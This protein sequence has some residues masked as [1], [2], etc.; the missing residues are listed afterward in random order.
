MNSSYTGSDFR[1]MINVNLDNGAASALDRATKLLA[2][3][4]DGVQKAAESAL[5]RAGISGRA[6]AAREVGK[7]YYLRSSDFK[8]Y[9]KS[10]Q[11]VSRSGG[12]ITVSLNFRGFHVP[13]IRFKTAL[14]SSGLIR[15]RV[16]R[17]SSGDVLR[18]VFK[19]TMPNS[20]HIGLF[21]R[22]KKT[23]DNGEIRTVI[24]QKYGPSV[25][26]M[27]G[28]NPELA[29]AVGNDIEKTFAERMN[30]EVLAVM[31]GWRR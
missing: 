21:E 19:Q 24:S 11:H 27:M 23:S 15:T 13:L 20:G 9:T 10:S 14:T 17:T 29:D 28:A 3:F 30:H 12:D 5:N 25:P 2:G 1:G 8:K 22:V 18:H 26:Q 31:N 7:Q 4:P 16:K 6:A